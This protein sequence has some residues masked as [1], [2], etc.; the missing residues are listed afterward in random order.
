MTK[1]DDEDFKN[2]TKFILYYI[3][4]NVKVRDH[5]HISENIGVPHLEIIIAMLK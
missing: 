1:G 2:A 3:D 5:C 4:A